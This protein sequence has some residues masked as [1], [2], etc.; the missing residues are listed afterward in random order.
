MSA[1]GELVGRVARAATPTALGLFGVFLL[2]APL[3]LVEGRAPTPLI[4]LIV[5]YFWSLYSPRHLPAASVFLIGLLQDL[6]SG[7][8]LGLWP[9]VYLAIQ[10]VAVS[11]QKYFL[12]REWHVVWMG[13]AAAAIGVSVILWL[14]MSLLSATLLPIGGLAGQMAVTLALYP[15]FAAAFSDLHRRVVIEV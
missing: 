8:P 15:I 5:V 13:F 1:R 12:G 7:G 9:A 14:F 6:L 10:Y 3:R 2:A 11:Q 4:P